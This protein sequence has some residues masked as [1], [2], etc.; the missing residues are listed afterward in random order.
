MLD[1]RSRSEVHQP[2]ERAERSPLSERVTRSGAALSTPEAAAALGVSAQSVR[3]AIARGELAADRLGRSYR[4]Q[5]EELARFARRRGR[6]DHDAT[7]VRIV[8]LPPA[9]AAHALP[10]PGSRFVGREAELAALTAL[11]ADPAERLVTLT[12]PGGIGKTRLALAVAAAVQDHFPDGVRFIDLSAVTRPHLLVPAMAQQLGLRDHTAQDPRDRLA[13][14][15][16]GK[17]LLLVLDNFEQIL[18]A[19]PE[20]AR[21]V[22]EA[23]GMSVLITSRAPLRIGGERE[24]PVPPLVL[25]AANAAPDALLASD[26]GRLFVDRACGYDPGF[27]VDDESAP[28]I[29]EIC[30][31][32]DVLPLAIELAAARCKVLPPRHLRDRLER[33]LPLL[34]HGARDAPARL[35]T[36]RDAIAWSYDHLTLEEQRLF[37][38]LAVFAGGCT[39]EA[40]DW[41]AGA[42]L[43]A[44]GFEGADSGSIPGTRHLAPGTLDLV[45]ALIEQSLLVRELGPEGEPRFRMLETIREY[46]LERL[47]PEEEHAARAEHARFYLVIMQS[48]RQWTYVHATS[49]PFFRL[50]ADEA[51]LRAAHDWLAEHGPAADLAAMVA[52]SYR[53]W[54][55]WG[56]LHDAQA[57]I[58]RAL[59]NRDGASPADCARL[60]IGHA[61]LLMAQGHVA[62]AEAALAQGVASSRAAGDQV[63]LALALIS[64]GAAMNLGGQYTEG[65][66]HL[67]EALTVAETIEEPRLR[68]AMAGRA[69]ANMGVFARGRGDLALAATRIE[70][71]LRRYQGHGLDLAETRALMDLAGIAR[72]QGNLRLAAERYL[73]C[74][75]GTTRQGETR[76]VADALALIASIA[77]AWG[78]HRKALLLFGAASDLHERAG[79]AMIFP[80]DAGRVSRDLAALREALGEREA[81][82]L[83][84]EGRTLPWSHVIAIAAALVPDSGRKAARAET[85]DRLTRRERDVL[86]LL[87]E[88]RT[89]RE[90]ADA[91]FLSPRTV[92]WHMRSILA[93][94]DA[95]SRRA[96]VAQ[97]RAE[98]LISP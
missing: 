56:R 18:H 91:L 8:A 66:A 87:A 26:A 76:L 30:T 83:L 55:N 16:R 85:P 96:A 4:I 6:P 68:A 28:L 67:A 29:A 79:T 49:A 88:A 20:V 33:R 75:E 86:Q 45:G 40:A 5:P 92:N 97:A 10:V 57:W 70:E 41:V 82:A 64:S 62:R 53:Y 69:L 12:G 48:L 84:A 1:D 31:R 43:Q 54:Y 93:K 36:M 7:S 50:A 59:A 95:S 39:L 14:Y 19:A 44:P 38:R 58:E 47:P 27:T 32:L 74:I 90:I 65:E 23:P 52:A 11:L 34:T 89:D 15:L 46:G 24:W 71:S 9:P 2:P 73:A 72:D 98:G 63:D 51:N 35:R 22:A 94:L 21:V 42:G 77:T 37:R 80:L 61:S 17:R 78:Q 81:A 13:A 60:L 25:A 3:R